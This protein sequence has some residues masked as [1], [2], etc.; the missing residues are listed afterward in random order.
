MNN[1]SSGN[2]AAPLAVTAHADT[3]GPLTIAEIDERLTEVG[4]HEEDGDADTGRE[5][6]SPPAEWTWAVSTCG[7]VNTMID[8]WA[9]DRA[10]GAAPLARLQIHQAGLRA[11]VWLH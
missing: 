1:K 6:V 2:G 5:I 9:T 11:S 4:I 3:G 10:A 8:G 7:Y